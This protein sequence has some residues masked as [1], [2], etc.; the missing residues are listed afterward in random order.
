MTFSCSQASRECFALKKL[1][2]NKE[3]IA[4]AETCLEAKDK[5]DIEKLTD[6]YNRCTGFDRNYKE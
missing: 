1:N 6:G 2:D 3:I 5:V 4:E